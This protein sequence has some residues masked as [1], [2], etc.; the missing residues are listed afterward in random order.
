MFNKLLPPAGYTGSD[1]WYEMT[2][3]DDWQAFAYC[4]LQKSGINK[5]KIFKT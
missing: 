3:L 5:S 2:S 1:C 4:V